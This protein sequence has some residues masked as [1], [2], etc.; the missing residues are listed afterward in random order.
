MEPASVDW[1]ILLKKSSDTINAINKE[2]TNVYMHTPLSEAKE[3]RD[4]AISLLIE[5]YP[6]YSLIK[7]C[8]HSMT[9]CNIQSIQTILNKII[10]RGG[11]STI[12]IEGVVNNTTGGLIDTTSY[13]K[14]Y[15]ESKDIHVLVAPSFTHNE[16][17]Q[18]LSIC[19]YADKRG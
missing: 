8:S 7:V 18:I 12:Y 5:P 19:N 2:L 4:H 17:R 3:I 13:V 14:T 15:M 16:N 10:A 6:K 11:G 1:L 9:T